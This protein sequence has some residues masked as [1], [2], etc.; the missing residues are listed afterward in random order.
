MPWPEVSETLR[1]FAWGMARAALDRSDGI[2]GF[3]AQATFSVGDGPFEISLVTRCGRRRL[4]IFSAIQR[5][6]D[7][8]EREL[9]EAFDIKEFRREI[10]IDGA[11]PLDVLEA[12]VERWIAHEGQS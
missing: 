7:R 5:L 3:G 12:K 8:A 1:S 9:G 10:L 4:V 6:R 2:G 11:L